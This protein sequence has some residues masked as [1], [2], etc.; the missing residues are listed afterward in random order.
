MSRSEFEAARKEEDERLKVENQTL[1]DQVEARV[2]HNLTA[3]RTLDNYPLNMTNFN[4]LAVRKVPNEFVKKG[5]YSFRCA[6]NAL[7]NALPTN[8]MI[9]P[10]QMMLLRDMKLLQLIKCALKLFQKGE[11]KVRKAFLSSFY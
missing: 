9:T 2:Q 4:D 3:F 11:G 7:N 6:L 1:H 5:R 8:I 10:P